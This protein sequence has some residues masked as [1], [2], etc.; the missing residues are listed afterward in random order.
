VDLL[1]FLPGDAQPMKNTA[2]INSP[3]VVLFVVIVG[4]VVILAVLIGE[5]IKDK[6]DLH[7]KKKRIRQEDE[8]RFR[9][10]EEARNDFS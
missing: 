3:H 6:I 1:D 7:I 10:A 8:A 4:L 5:I 2:N 9:I